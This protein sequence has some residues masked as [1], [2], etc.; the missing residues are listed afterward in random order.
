MKYASTAIL[1]VWTILA[2]AQ[3]DIKPSDEFS[4]TGLVNQEVKFGIAD[5]EKVPSK[6]IDD[7][8]ITNH[9]GEP[10]GTAK[11]LKAISL[12]SLLEKIEFKTESPKVLSEFYLTFVATDNYKVV[13]SWNEIFNTATGDS[14][15]LIVEKDGKKIS[16]MPERILVITPSDS[17]TGRRNIKG[18][19]KIV[20]GRVE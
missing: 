14:I 7:I 20:V 19:S 13:Y 16:E 9:L 6:K 18:L 17:K 2:N 5:L 1:L 10:R 12:K 3:K 4:V 8:V 11:N 15:Y